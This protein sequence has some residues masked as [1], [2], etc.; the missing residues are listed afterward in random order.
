MNARTI[1]ILGGATLVL[2]LLAVW[3]KRDSGGQSSDEP[4]GAKLYPGLDAKVNLVTSIEIES[5]DEQYTLEKKGDTWT[6]AQKGGYPV[7]FDKV[8]E[9]INAIAFFEIVEQKTSKPDLYER[10]AVQDP[11]STSS[12]PEAASAT[13]VAL[14]DATGLVLA[15]VILGKA[16]TGG[17]MLAGRSLFV[18]KAGEAQ[19]FEV[20]GQVN[21]GGNSTLWLDKE[22]VKIP[23]ERVRRVV[24]THPDGER[25]EVVKNERKDA[26][27]VVTG[28]PEGREL[29]YPAVTD[30]IGSALGY[31][32]FENVK[33]ASEV[34]FESQAVV[35]EYETWDGL[36]ITAKVVKRDEK[37]YAKFECVYDPALRVEPATVTPP[38]EGEVEA[39]GETPPPAEDP[40]ATEEQVRA[41]AEQLTARLPQWAYEL[42]GYRASSLE[43]RVEELLK[44]LPD[45]DEPP[46]APPESTPPPP[47]DGHDHGDGQGD[48]GEDR[49]E[50][51]R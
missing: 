50:G 31:M 3:A 4:T 38:P 29:K 9:V 41:E 7:Q 20:K 51:G 19:A 8:R 42:P 48:G 17:D 11:K 34:D 33:P 13:R 5:K 46:P 36:R 2:A 26:N 1:Q 27:F 35:T 45:V 6:I 16:N 32:T 43:M 24:I 28:M 25:L 37:A 10:L 49:A 40:L 22:I 18:R 21:V 39:E 14:R 12:D 15:D 23:R 30:Q 47:G 44:P